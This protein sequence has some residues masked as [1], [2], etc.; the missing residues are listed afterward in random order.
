MAPTHVPDYI[1]R[2][3]SIVAIEHTQTTA[4]RDALQ[5]F[6]SHCRRIEPTTTQTVTSSM[7]IDPTH[8]LRGKSQQDSSLQRLREAYRQT[9]MAV[10]HYEDEYNEPLAENLAAE[11]G[12]AL[13]T[14]L[15]S[16]QHLTPHLI[17]TLHHAV[18]QAAAERDAFLTDLDREAAALNTAHATLTDITQWLADRAVQPFENWSID[19]RYATHDTLRTYKHQCDMLAAERQEMLYAGQITVSRI[20]TDLFTTYLY[21]AL[22]VTYPVLADLAAVGDL[23]EQARHRVEQVLV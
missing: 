2:A 6:A 22:D 5:Q 9:V 4:E 14:A 21:Q 3:Q 8:M 16:E 23:L 7:V 10:P 12:E 11:V 18:Q 19:E 1:P 13:A 17:Q 20:E 15:T